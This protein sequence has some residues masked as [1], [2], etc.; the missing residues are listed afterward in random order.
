MPL[1]FLK[2][3]IPVEIEPCPIMDTSVE[4]RFDTNVPSAA[5]FGILYSI[6]QKEFTEPVE[7]LPIQKIPEEMRLANDEL[8]YQPHY[9]LKNNNFV[10]Q[11]GPQVLSIGCIRDYPGWTI[12]KEKIIDSLIKLKE[13]GIPTKVTRLGLRYINFFNNIDIFEKLDSDIFS[14]NT[15]LISRNS[16]V[17]T[18]FAE[19]GLIYIVQISNS[20]TLIRDTESIYGS[21]IDLDVSTSIQ[22]EGFFDNVDEQISRLHDAEK[23][24]FFGLLSNDYL[25]SF[26]TTYA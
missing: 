11:I 19:S 26:K 5:I 12:Y 7:M 1:P 23:H 21:M 9:R 2:K 15:L 22:L 4:I 8:R 13:S 16:F 6:F 25:N 20:G 17:R 10:I 3:Q 24:V 18:Q 14:R